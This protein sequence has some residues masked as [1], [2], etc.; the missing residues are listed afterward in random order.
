MCLNFIF[1]GCISF[2]FFNLKHCQRYR[3]AEVQYK[4]LFSD[5]LENIADIIMFS[6]PQIL[7][8]IS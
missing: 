8:L 4:E 7:L 5:L 6:H 2:F 1:D 3:K